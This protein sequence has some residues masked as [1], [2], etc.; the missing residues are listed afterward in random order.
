[1]NK[2]D[3]AH[4]MVPRTRDQRLQ[5]AANVRVRNDEA[6]LNDL[7]AREDIRGYHKFVDNA[8]LNNP[9]PK[10]SHWASAPLD[11]HEKDFAEYDRQERERERQIKH[12]R[13]ESRRMQ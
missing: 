9:D 8:R 3:F 2:L 11:R 10:S 6:Y 4:N 12:Q 13:I 5:M 1:M 7:R